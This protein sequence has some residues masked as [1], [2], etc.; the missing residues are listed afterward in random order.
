M[1]EKISYFE[2]TNFRALHTLSIYSNISKIRILIQIKLCRDTRIQV[3]SSKNN[4]FSTKEAISYI[5]WTEKRKKVIVCEILES[6]GSLSSSIVPILS[7]KLQIIVC[8]GRNTILTLSKLELFCQYI[9][10]FYQYVLS[11]RAPSLM[12]WASKVRL[13]FA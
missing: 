3:D 11:Q 10:T 2:M 1:A 6:S 8:R 9:M 13:Q 7:W 4:H 12:M 5:P